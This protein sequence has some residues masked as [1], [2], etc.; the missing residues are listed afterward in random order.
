MADPVF[1]KADQYERVKELL[2]DGEELYMVYDCKGR[3]SGFVGVTDRRLIMRDDGLR[4]KSILSVPYSRVHSVG[5]SSDQNF[6]R[7]NTSSLSFA[8]GSDSWE[9]EFKGDGKAQNA[10]AQIMK[11]VLAQ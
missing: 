4:G 6:I 1:D 10:Y 5:V 11:H 3:G 9:F 7:S 8:A 2:L